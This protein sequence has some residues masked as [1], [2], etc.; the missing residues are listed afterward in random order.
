MFRFKGKKHLLNIY[1]YIVLVFKTL[2]SLMELIGGI[3]MFIIKHD[4]LKNLINTIAL[5]ELQRDP[6]D[7]LMNSLI[8]FGKDFSIGSQYT[9]ALFMIVQGSAKL[10]VIW[11]LIKKKVWAYPLAAAVFFAFITYEIYSFINNN[12]LIVLGATLIDVAFIV[13][14]ILEYRLMKKEQTKSQGPTCDE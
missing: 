3:L 8:E 6:N 5:P 14:I 7:I 1:F 11:L 9:V 12:S 4:N 2:T 13:I 10:I